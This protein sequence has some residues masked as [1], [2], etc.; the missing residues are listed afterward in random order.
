MI[1]P[2]IDLKREYDF[3]RKDITKVLLSVVKRGNFI[4]GEEVA[5][6]EN[7][8]AKY[9]G[10]KYAVVVANG[11]DALFLAL[12][13]LG[14]GKGDEVIVP[15]FTF[16]STAFAVTH[17]GA[18]PILVDVLAENS[19]IDPEDIVKKIT[20]KTKAIIPVHLYG[21]P[22]DMKKIKN[23]AE[24]YKLFIIEDAAQSHGAEYSKKKTGSLGDIGC[25]SF[26]PTKNL[27]CYG[28]GGAVVT[29]D[30]NIAEKIR[31]LRN[32]GQNKKYFFSQ[33]GINSRLDEIQAAVLRLK[34][35][36][37]NKWNSRRKEIAKLYNERLPK[38]VKRLKIIKNVHS[39]NHLYPIF[40]KERDRLMEYLSKK[41][42]STQIHYPVPIH[43]Q[44][45]YKTLSHKKGDF[46]NSEHMASHE[47]S[48]PIHAFLANSEVK[49]ITD[50][51]NSFFK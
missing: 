12:K 17:A 22:A 36:Y 25:F 47:L 20:R 40:L 1:I 28:D 30:K 16:I 7:E 29:D 14:I 32:Y 35:K 44:K 6:F 31:S 39:V 10:V 11:T 5:A 50:C 26:Y 34:L 51:I 48:L 23:I 33:L 49:Y 45:I 8:W 3:L 18:T 46:P 43:S 15:S 41:G 19:S 4:L 27:G 2:F 37:L 9:I 21:N 24:K 38:E 13:A 42:I